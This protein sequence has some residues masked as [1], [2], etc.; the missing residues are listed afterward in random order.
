MFKGSTDDQLDSLCKTQNGFCLQIDWFKPFSD[1]SMIIGQT[2][3]RLNGNPCYNFIGQTS[4]RF[5]KRQ[6]RLKKKTAFKNRFR[7][8]FQTFSLTKKSALP[9]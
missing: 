6:L 8:V 9:V 7:I 5:E 1:K 4:R 2:L 3:Y